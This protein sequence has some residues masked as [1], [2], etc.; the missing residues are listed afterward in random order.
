MLARH[1]AAAVD[2]GTVIPGEIELITGANGTI[3]V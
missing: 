2:S 3:F 1:H